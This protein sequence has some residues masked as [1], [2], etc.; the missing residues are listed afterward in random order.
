V[1][2]LICKKLPLGS[3]LALRETCKTTRK[4]V[5]VENRST[6]TEA[7]KEIQIVLR[8]LGSDL[9]RFLSEVQNLPFSNFNLRIQSVENYGK[10]NVIK[11]MER[12]APIIQRLT[13]SSFWKCT[14]DAEWGFYEGL[15]VLEKLHIEEM[16]LPS[17]GTTSRIPPCIQKLKLLEILNSEEF[18]AENVIPYCFQLFET[19][20]ELQTFTPCSVSYFNSLMDE[21]TNDQSLLET[22]LRHFI[23]SWERRRAGLGREGGDE[24]LKAINWCYIYFDGYFEQV[25]PLWF[26]LLRKILHHPANILMHHVSSEMLDCVEEQ[27]PLWNQF[28]ERIVSLNPMKWSA[29]YVEM[30][31]PNL[32]HFCVLDDEAAGARDLDP[33]DFSHPEWPKLKAIYTGQEGLD[34]V[35]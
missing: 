8:M 13:V 34:L 19:A 35:K 26:E 22:Y 17:S 32:D 33:E 2:N 30:E 15:Q 12:Y 3:L 7:L 24:T 29:K 6:L 16:V 21:K 14:S 11:F 28:V 9:G 23:E 4:W 27:L 1:T 10:G 20:K 5:D 31:M 18:E 25:L